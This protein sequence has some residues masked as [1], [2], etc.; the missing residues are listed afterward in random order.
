MQPEQRHPTQG[1]GP[2][3]PSGG[4][5][6][7]TAAPQQRHAISIPSYREV[8]AAQ[9]APSAI[10]NLFIPSSSNVGAKGAGGE[11]P[12]HMQ[13]QQHLQQQQQ[14]MTPPPLPPKQQQQQ[15]HYPPSGS[16]ITTNHPTS[17]PLPASRTVN[18]NNLP[19]INLNVITVSRRQQGNPVLK[20]IRNIRWQYGD[21]IPDYLLG[22]STAALFLSLR[23]HLLNPNYV[24]T[25]IKEIGRAYR[26]R[27]LLVHVDTEDAVEP[28]AQK[29]LG[30]DYV[31]R[32]TA[33][34]TTIRGVNRTDVKT[35]GDTFGSVAA[36]LQANEAELK[37]CPGVGPVKARRLFE[38][39]H[40]PFRRNLN[41][42]A[43]LEAQHHR[44]QQQ[45]EQ[46]PVLEQVLAGE[47]DENEDEEAVLDE[48]F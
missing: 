27:V 1:V 8:Q 38:T 42:P 12:R 37:A 43:T 13:Q 6:A 11:T 4:Q 44:H 22:Q 36:V 35:L 30:T 10:P 29:E 34:L 25:R 23:Y 48:V 46:I 40:E 18:N 19:P 32:A 39:F 47:G 15:Q 2:A 41:A 33:A 5:D 21:I 45:Q 24:H 9:R 28:L 20:Y 31:S 26:L 17:Q 14:Q 16:P 3:Q 7:P